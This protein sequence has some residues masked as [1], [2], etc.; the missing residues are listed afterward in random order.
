MKSFSNRSMDANYF[1]I[2]IFDYICIFKLPVTI[3][4]SI[5]RMVNV[6]V[7]GKQFLKNW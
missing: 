1:V 7:I 3:R 6:N 2:D 5:G 4:F